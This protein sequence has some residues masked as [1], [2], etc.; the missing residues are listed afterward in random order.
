MYEQRHLGDLGRLGDAND[1]GEIEILAD[2]FVHH[3]LHAAFCR[4]AQRR[5][6][7]AHGVKMSRKHVV[8]AHAV[9]NLEGQIARRERIDQGVEMSF[10]DIR[11]LVEHVHAPGAERA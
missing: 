4:H 7:T 1:G 5:Q 9:R 2:H 8:G 10:V 11:Q 6:P 3:A